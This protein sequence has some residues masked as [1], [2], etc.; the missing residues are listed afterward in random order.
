M[1]VSWRQALVD[2]THRLLVLSDPSLSHTSG[3]WGLWEKEPKV[4]R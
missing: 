1:G 2:L 3:R 4:W